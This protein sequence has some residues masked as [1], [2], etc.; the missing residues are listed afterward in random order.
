MAKVELV[1]Q[2][3]IL[4]FT[5]VSSLMRAQT[6]TVLAGLE[7]DRKRNLLLFLQEAELILRDK[8]TINLLN[9]DLSEANLS[10][11]D[12]RKTDLMGVNLSGADLSN[13]RLNNALLRWA[14]LSG[15]DLNG[16]DLSGANLESVTG[17]TKEELEESGAYLRQTTMPDGSKSS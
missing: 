1:G 16:A 17:I 11:A 15:A 3:K 12:L 13:A 4:P 14:N 9:G 5:K 8:P 6:L 10:E 2:P 7:P